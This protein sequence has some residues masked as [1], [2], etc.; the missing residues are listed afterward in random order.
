MQNQAPTDDAIRVRHVL[1]LLCPRGMREM[2][3]P[4]VHMALAQIPTESLSALALDLESAFNPDDT[5]NVTRLIEVGKQ[6]GLTDEM[7]SGYRQSFESFI[8]TKTEPPE[9]L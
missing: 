4:L 8:A 9:S 7:V 3:A 1:M 2:F 5:V 6:F